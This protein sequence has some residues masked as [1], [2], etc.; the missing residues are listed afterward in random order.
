L[1]EKSHKKI[2]ILVGDSS[3][4]VGFA[5]E[6]LGVACQYMEIVRDQDLLGHEESLLYRVDALRLVDL[7][8]D[9]RAKTNV[10]S[11][12]EI[13]KGSAGANAIVKYASGILGIEHPD[14]NLV[15][16]TAD[17]LL[18]EEVGDVR[19]AIW[20]AVWLLTGP[21]PGEFQR[22]PDPWTTPRAWMPKDVDPAYRLNSLYRDLVGYVFAR[23]DDANA[24]KKFG[25]T[26]AKFS[27]LKNFTL[28]LS[29]VYASLR[30]LSKW[31]TQK[32]DPLICALKITRIWETK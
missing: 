2:N 19:A 28:D 23:G 27:R 8:P 32:S 20:E 7:S 25:V 30:D 13:Q 15:Q 17:L 21:T 14:R 3:A 5:E 29:R 24:A 16:R 10:W 31:L 1:S 9:V 26:P 11:L 6:V 4:Q 12:E 22:W 18:S